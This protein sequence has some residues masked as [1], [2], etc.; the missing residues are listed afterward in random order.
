MKQNKQVFIP[1]IIDCIFKILKLLNISH[2]KLYPPK[3]NM[4]LI[5]LNKTIELYSA[6]KKNTKG[7]DECSVKNPATSSDSMKFIYLNK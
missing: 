6:K 3:N 7:T 5:Q 1:N 2:G 4:E